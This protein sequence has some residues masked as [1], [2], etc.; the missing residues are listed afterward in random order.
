M[1]PKSKGDDLRQLKELLKL[2]NRTYLVWFKYAA[3]EFLCDIQDLRSVFVL[4]EV[5]ALPDGAVYLFE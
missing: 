2:N 3:R 4:K 1:L 5:V